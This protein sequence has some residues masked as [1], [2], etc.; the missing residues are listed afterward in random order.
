V[1]LN[2]PMRPGER[3]FVAK[4]WVES[5]ASSALSKLVSHSGTEGRTDDF[6]RP[7]PEYWACWNALVN[8]L[9]DR[10][11]TIVAAD[12]DDGGPALVAGFL[13][14]EPWESAVAVHYVYTRLSYRKL[15]VARALVSELPGGPV[16]YTHRSR[17]IARPP[18]GWQFSIRPLLD[19]RPR[20]AA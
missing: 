4:S 6:W 15:G 9:L 5:F 14:W 18:E 10:C 1:I 7:N 2:R 8:S 3:A 20:E 11:I 13:C 12:S 19:T 17:G 16:Y